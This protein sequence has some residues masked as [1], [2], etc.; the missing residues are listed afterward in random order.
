[1]IVI[2]NVYIDSI[3]T[4]LESEKRYERKQEEQ[5][6]R[7]ERDKFNQALKQSPEQ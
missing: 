6:Y 4:R 5:K 3:V 1:M 2:M 7:S